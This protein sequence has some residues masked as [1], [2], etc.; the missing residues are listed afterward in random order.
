MTIKTINPF[1]RQKIVESAI[2]GMSDETKYI[3]E[4]GGVFFQYGHLVLVEDPGVWVVKNNVAKKS[5]FLPLYLSSATS[6]VALDYMANMEK[7][8]K[9]GHVDG[10]NHAKNE[11]R[12][13]LKLTPIDDDDL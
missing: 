4:S 5:I 6:V 2:A 3:L 7:A 12:E 9:T 8:Y 1:D 10:K 13:W 11:F